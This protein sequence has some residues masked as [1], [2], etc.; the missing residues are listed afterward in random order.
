MVPAAA[1]TI[2]FPIVQ[3][4]AVGET[5]W[6]EIPA[7]GGAEPDHPAPAV[8]VT[9]GPPTS[10]DLA[11]HDEDASG[12]ATTRP[13]DDDDSSNTGL[14]IGII[15]GVAVVLGGAAVIAAKRKKS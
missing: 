12:D 9:D 10:A 14:V 4:C 8:L 3:T 5:A 7:E 6:I 1:G 15:A 11:P 13:S 2:Y